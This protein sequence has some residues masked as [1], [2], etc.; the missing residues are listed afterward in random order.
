MSTFKVTWEITMDAENTKQA[1]RDAWMIL[2]DLPNPANTATFL[3]V[4]DEEGRHIDEF[5][6][7]K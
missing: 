2:T 3:D 5:D 4:Y 7:R 1:V 6:M